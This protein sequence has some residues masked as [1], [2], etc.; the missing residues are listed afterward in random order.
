MDPITIAMLAMAGVQGAAKIGGAISDKVKANK[1]E[2][3][4]GTRPDYEV[5]ASVKKI[6]E[7]AQKDADSREA[8]PG[9]QQRR[10]QIRASEAK[11][12]GQI[13]QMA[14]SS[15]GAITGLLGNQER[16]SRSMRD[17][18]VMASEF[19]ER[20]RVREQQRLDSAYGAQ[21][22]YE[23]EAW[24]QNQLLPWEINMN[25]SDAYRNSAREGLYQGIDAVGSGV[26]GAMG[27]QAQLDMARRRYPNYGDQGGYSAGPT[28]DTS[29]MNQPS[30]WYSPPPQPSSERVD[31]MGYTFGDFGSFDPNSGWNYNIP[32]L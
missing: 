2:K 18:Q 31:P 6:L 30:N 14:D 3:E 15:V 26:M 17:L 1:A 5:P 7:L 12:A 16:V 29:A 28:V 10:E 21:A 22:Q 4:A 20:N 19:Q 9:F 13:A 25:M 27:T 23:N 24:R 11:G 32:K 8:M